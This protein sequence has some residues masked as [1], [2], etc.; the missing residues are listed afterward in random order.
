MSFQANVAN[1]DFSYFDFFRSNNLSLKYHRF[2][3]SGCKA[4]EIRKFVLRAK[5]QFFFQS[6]PTK[7]ILNFPLNHIS[8]VLQSFVL[9]VICPKISCPII[10]CTT[11]TFSLNHLH[12]NQLTYTHLSYN[13]LTY[14][15]FSYTSFV[16]QGGENFICPL[17]HLFYRAKKTSFVLHIIC[18]TGWRKLHLYFTSFVLQGRENF[19]CPSHHLS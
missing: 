4:I 6:F 16:L 3:P 5:T 9:D 7:F 18:P 15:Y 8:F 2:K 1:L 14:N 19:I 17:H 13:H 12:Y 11:R 10:I